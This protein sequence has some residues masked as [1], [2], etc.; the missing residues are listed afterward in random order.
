MRVVCSRSTLKIYQDI[1]RETMRT[2]DEMH[3]S[4]ADVLTTAEQDVFRNFQSEKDR[5]ELFLE[6]V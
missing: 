6:K 1:A 4:P 2:V 5:Q 3:M